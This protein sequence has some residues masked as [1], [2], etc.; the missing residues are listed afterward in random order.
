MT[1]VGILII[2]VFKFHNYLL[3]DKTGYTRQHRY[4]FP[5]SEFKNLKHTEIV[6][7]L[8]AVALFSR[9]EI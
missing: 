2:F 7:C 5:Y 4:L 6:K 8:Q 3:R 1:V 9:T